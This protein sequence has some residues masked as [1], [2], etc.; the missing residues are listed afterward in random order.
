MTQ[1]HAVLE[2]WREAERAL[3]ELGPSLSS[4][5]RH[6]LESEIEAL[7]GLYQ[8]VQDMHGHDIAPGSA[9]SG[10]GPPGSAAIVAVEDARHRLQQTLSRLRSDVDRVPSIGGDVSLAR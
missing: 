7:R 9:Q 3:E 6:A 8:G 4:G 1:T 2:I 5:D 10:T